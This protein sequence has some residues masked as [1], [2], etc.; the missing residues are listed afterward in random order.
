MNPGMQEDAQE[1]LLRLFEKIGDDLDSDENPANIFAG[2]LTHY[3]ICKTVNVT[4]ERKEMFY[5]MS[6]DV[7]DSCDVQEAM[8]KLF[9][10]DILEGDNQYKTKDHGLQDALKGQSI[11]RLPKVLY[12]HL[13]RFEYDIETGNMRKI[14]KAVNF[15][16][17]LDLNRY[18]DVNM[19]NDI[20]L[21]EN[22]MFNHSNYELNAIILHHGN[23]N[24]GHYTCF[25]R[26]YDAQHCDIWHR[27]NDEI[28]SEVDIDTM[29]KESV[30]GNCEIRQNAD[31]FSKNAYILQ[32]IR[33]ENTTKLSSSVQFLPE[34]L[35]YVRSKG[36]LKS[37]TKLHK[38]AKVTTRISRNFVAAGLALHYWKK[39]V[40]KEAMRNR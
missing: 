38:E 26:P 37:T 8:D 7:A 10:P 29:I 17:N 25:A 32:Y 34:S 11:S 9:T 1:F 35:G 36:S 20:A 28:F 4:K 6:I 40:Y 19:K 15:P 27:L 13:K 22:P 14:S 33:R 30:G 2:E 24:M 16:M 3:I 31:D 21:K 12:I 5:D 23:G 18:V 39:T